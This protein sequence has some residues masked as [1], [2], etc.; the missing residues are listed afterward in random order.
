MNLL[1]KLFA[2]VA[3]S[4]SFTALALGYASPGSPTGYVNDFA[5]I[6]D[7][8]WIQTI[9]DTLKTFESE[10]GVQIA[11]VTIPNLGGDTIENYAVKLFQEWGIGKKGKDNGILILISQADRTVRIEVGYGL[12]G[13]ITDAESSQIIQ[14]KMIP[15]LKNGN[16]TEAVAEALIEIESKIG[17]PNSGQGQS[18]QTQQ[19]YQENTATNEK[20]SINFTI[21]FVGAII[22]A[23]MRF[24]EFLYIGRQKKLG[25]VVQVLI[26]AVGLGT[27]FVPG[28][29]MSDVLSVTLTAFIFYN[30]IY[31]FGEFLLKLLFFMALFSRRGGGGSG[32]GFG[33]FGGGRSGGS[34]ASGKW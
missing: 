17:N 22:I 1:K 20:K 16:A 2:T 25:I 12:E 13:T 8:S 15:N 31:W 27:Y 10:N 24:I 26:L 23:I 11:V 3:L 19:S 9:N 5:K 34:G 29:T 4:L 32:G 6:L 30:L 21:G 33:G 18:G 14:N 28:N 7:A